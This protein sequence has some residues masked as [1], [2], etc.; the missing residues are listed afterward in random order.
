M[1]IPFAGTRLFGDKA[2]SALKCFW[3]SSVT[4][5][6]LGLLAAPHQPHSSLRP[7][8]GYGRGYQSHLFHQGHPPWPA[9]FP[10][11][12]WLCTRLPQALWDPKPD[13][14]Q[15]CRSSGSCSL[16]TPIVCLSVA[17]APC[18][19]QDQAPPVP[20]A[21]CNIGQWVLQTVRRGYVLPFWKPLLLCHRPQIG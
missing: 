2:D 7:F 11:F 19:W 14:C 3:E 13:V 5:Q 10:A 9:G 12:S 16:Q 15:V 1:D 4:V 20:L 8:R 18:W 6:S 21:E 17:H